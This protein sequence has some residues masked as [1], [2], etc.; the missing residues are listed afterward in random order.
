[1]Y[2]DAVIENHKQTTALDGSHGKGK[3]RNMVTSDIFESGRVGNRRA[4][5]TALSL[6]QKCFQKESGED[7]PVI[8]CGNGR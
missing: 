2:A 6:Y 1:M 4:S 8:P 3:L 5:L 7:K